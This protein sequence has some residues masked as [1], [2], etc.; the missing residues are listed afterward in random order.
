MSRTFRVITRIPGEDQDDTIKMINLNQEMFI[1][2][3][4]NK[5]K[6]WHLNE[7]LTQ[8]PSHSIEEIMAMAKCYLK[9]EKNN[10]RKREGN[11]LMGD[12]NPHYMS[13]NII[14]VEL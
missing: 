6:A 8:K 9:G 7:P 2:V 4:Q 11:T 1:K 10:V 3:F 14:W 13:V 12:L 5:L